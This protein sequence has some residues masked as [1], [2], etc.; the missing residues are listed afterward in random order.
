MVCH[1]V[2][3]HII[4]LLL[5]FLNFLSMNAIE[6]TSPEGL[7]SVVVLSSLLTKRC[8]NILLCGHKRCF[9]FSAMWAQYLAYLV[10][11]NNNNNDN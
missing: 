1:V 6:F 3:S 4:E 9:I 7:P 10:A 5:L 11:N 8:H 2:N